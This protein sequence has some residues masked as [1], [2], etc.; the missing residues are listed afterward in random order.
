MDTGN[1]GVLQSISVA[2]VRHSATEHR[3]SGNPRWP[4]P[5]KGFNL[6]LCSNHVYFTSQFKDKSCP[7]HPP[8]SAPGR[9]PSES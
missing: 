1:S 9:A 6:K 8:C 3:H 4:V 7:V 5:I 2:R